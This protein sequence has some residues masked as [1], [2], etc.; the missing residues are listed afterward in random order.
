MSGGDVGWLVLA[1]SLGSALGYLSARRLRTLAYRYPDEQD[2]PDP[3]RRLWVVP[4]AGI[5]AVLLTWRTLVAD[6]GHGW[7]AVAVVAA[8]MLVAAPV[9][10]HLA[11]IDL[12][13]RRL[14]DRLVGPWVAVSAGGLW[15]AVALGADATAGRRALLAGAAYAG[16]FLILAL[17][18]LLWS[19]Q[20]IG[21]G[22]VKLAGALGVL[23]GWFGWLQVVVGIYA[24]ILLGGLAAGYLMLRRRAA[25]GDHLAF[26]PAMMS[27]AL[28]GILLPQ[29]S[30]I[31]L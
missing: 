9:G 21:F 4:A 29:Q 19:T 2:Q 7:P 27:G 13:V 18:S 10:T 3:G 14:P 25:A 8:V 17:L 15:L 5:V 23:L 24:G 11:A 12:D 16:F 30:L 6:G 28:I 1:A 22:D 26:G 20:G 31:P